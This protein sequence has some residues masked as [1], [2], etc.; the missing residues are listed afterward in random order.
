MGMF[1]NPGIRA[2]LVEWI[3]DV[4]PRVRAAIG[5]VPVVLW[6]KGVNAIRAARIAR[7]VTLVEEVD[8][9]IGF[10]RDV[11]IVVYP[12][13]CGAGIQTKVQQAMAC[14]RAVVARPMNIEPLGAT[15]GVECFASDNNAEMAEQIALLWQDELARERM[16]CAASQLI[17]ARFSRAAVGKRLEDIYARARGAAPCRA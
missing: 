14:R 16:G 12:Q 13:R 11:A 17:A 7:N 4:L 10:L 9:Y 2:G 1:E 15:S 8:D 6:G 5:D 3:R